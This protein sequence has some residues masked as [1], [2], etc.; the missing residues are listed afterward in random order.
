M[1]FTQAIKWVFAR[2]WNKQTLVFLFFLLLSTAFWLFQSLNEVYEYDFD[3]PVVIKGKPAGVVITSDVPQTVRVTLRD[4][5]VTLLN[6][7]YGDKL[8]PVVIDASG[9]T[10]GEG[11]VRYL[12]A[13]IM[14]QVRLYLQQGTQVTAVR[15][16]T[17]EVYYN[18]GRYRRVPVRVVGMPTAAAGYTITGGHISPDSVTVFAPNALLDTIRAV[19]VEAGNLRDLTHAVTVTQEIAGRRGVK[20]SPAG[21]KITYGVDRLVEKKLMLDVVAQN[22][23]PDVQLRTFPAQV[24]VTL[25]VSMSLYRNI[26]PEQF[27]LVV[28]YHDLPLDG[29]TTCPIRLIQAPA[30][31]SHVRLAQDEVEY[32]LETSHR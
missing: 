23:P 32:V 28:N 30:A 25:Q 13:D 9:F 15:P 14:R 29:S 17:L 12:A 4:R 11:Y 18:Q 21:V 3:V 6:Y 1:S 27:R 16:D 26:T 24:E 2:V 7:M 22:F 20:F 10:A 31:V 5:G 8:R 19:Y